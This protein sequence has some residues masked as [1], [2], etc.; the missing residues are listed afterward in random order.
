MADFDEILHDGPPM[1]SIV[2]LT[3]TL[4]AQ[5]TQAGIDAA[6]VEQR[7]SDTIVP[8]D[9]RLDTAGERAMALLDEASASTLD[10]KLELHGTLGEGGMGRVRLG[11]QRA[12][13]RAVAVK[14]LKSEHRD[15][16]SVLKLLREAWV[17]GALEHPNV[18][19]V[20]DIALEAD[21]APLIVLKR[22]EG[23]DWGSLMH[24]RRTVRERFGEDDLLEWNLRILMQVCNAIRFAH[25]RGVLHRDL[26]P[27]NVMIG[28][29]G[30]VYVVDWGIAVSLN[31]DGTGRLP[32]ASEAVEVAGTPLYMAPEMLGGAKSHLSERTDVYL[33]GAILYEIVAG[34][35]PHRGESF[36]EIVGCIAASEPEIGADVPEE[37]ARIIRHAMNRDADARF[38]NAEQ[39]RLAI[40]GFLQHRDATRLAERAEE[41]GEE[42]LALLA[43]D[44]GRSRDAEA[45]EGI[46]HLFGEC[47]FGFRHALEVWAD[48]EPARRAL[49]R[50]IGAMIEHELSLGEPEAARALLSEMDSVPEPLAER[51]REAREAKVKRGRELEEL[52]HDLDPSRGRRTRAF[53]A[54][55]I[56]GLWTL[57]PLGTQ[58]YLGS[59]APDHSPVAGVALSVFFLA[60]LGGAGLWARESM[61]GTAINRRIG[62]AAFLAI[63]LQLVARLV[64]MESGE[65]VLE[66]LHQQFLVWSG[67]AAMVAGS[68][69]RRLWVPAAGY[70]AGYVVLPFI[71]LDRALYVMSAANAVLLVTAS[72]LW[73]RPRE[74]LEKARVRVRERRAAHRRGLAE[75]VRP[76]ER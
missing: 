41:R 67:I 8:P 51:V 57:M 18:V 17:T 26:K 54:M 72:L 3:E 66:S 74:D 62:L 64:A 75:R 39:L 60:V 42:L 29:F 44:E 70:L 48:N 47:R 63:G 13:G 12:L 23:V 15:P 65:S 52:R 4:E 25:S 5:L 61:M 68:I 14:S 27:E 10:R 59:S 22:I 31:D 34:A 32:L 24:D 30:E 6:T 2:E 16:R 71:G 35:P 45:R 76:P 28:D 40:Q 43:S 33:L 58:L 19:P 37:L 1:P 20:Y 21:G 73:W 69:D 50:I 36:M 7:P 55:V 46:Y 53:L 49:D 11:T 38:E 9:Q 56:G